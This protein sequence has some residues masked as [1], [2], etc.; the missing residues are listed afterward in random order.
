M[1]HQQF[2]RYFWWF[3]RQMWKTAYSCWKLQAN[4]ILSTNR[5][6]HKILFLCSLYRCLVD[7]PSEQLL[8]GVLEPELVPAW[9]PTYRTAS[10]LQQHLSLRTQKK[11]TLYIEKLQKNELAISSL[12]L[13]DKKWP[14]SMRNHRRNWPSCLTLELYLHRSGIMSYVIL[15]IC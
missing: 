13:S 12:I 11:L 3:V 1:T 10:L 6:I 8:E 15:I 7:N 14:M 4:N 2:Q 9:H 5:Q